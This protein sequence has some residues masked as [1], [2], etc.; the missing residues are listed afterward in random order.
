M[1][2]PADC[3]PGAEQWEEF[4]S[5]VTG[6]TYIQYDYRAG[7]GALFSTVTYR[8]ESCRFLRD[9]WLAKRAQQKGANLQ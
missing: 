1:L 6:K 8:L 5:A 9:E 2:N 4:Q 7:D 3:K